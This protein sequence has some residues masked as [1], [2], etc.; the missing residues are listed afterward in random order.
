[1]PLPIK[2][3]SI[4]QIQTANLINLKVEIAK[5]IKDVKCGRVQ[6]MDI[7]AIKQKA[8]SLHK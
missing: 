2:K 7:Y 4:N 6:K 3:S 8:R 1:M 5:G